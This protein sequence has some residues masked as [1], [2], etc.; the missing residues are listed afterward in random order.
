MQPSAPVQEFTIHPLENGLTV[1]VEEM[2]WAS[3]AAMS[4]FLPLGAATD[5]EG[6][7]G[8]SSLLGELMQ[9]GAGEFDSRG[10]SEAFESLGIHRS[11]S[12]GVAGSMFSAVCLPEHLSEAS[13][14]LG[15]QLLSP[16]LPESDYPAV[17]ALALQELASLEDE[18]ASKVMVEL[19]KQFFP[20][21]FNRSQLG[22]VESVQ[23]ISLQDVERYHQTRI[24]PQGAIIGVAGKVSAQ[25]VIRF[26]EEAFGGW[27]GAADI[28]LPGALPTETQKFH[29]KKETAQLQLAL[30]YPSVDYSSPDYYSARVATSVLSGG[31]FGRLFVE[32]REKRGLV[33]RVSA[34]HQASKG[35]GA[36][37]VYAGTTPE[38][39]Q[40]CMDVT[41]K[42]LRGLSEGIPTDEL[43]RAKAD[44]KSRLVM[45][46]ELSSNRSAALVHDWWNLGRVR[47]VNEIKDSI[48]KVSSEDISSF[49]QKHPPKPLTLVCMGPHAVELSS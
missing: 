44:L 28:P 34:S 9:K 48:Q 26:V 12:V 15:L 39:G 22:T 29:V 4:I 10:I 40:E 21:P 33:Y 6:Q 41:L 43:E 13:N 19:S 11:H 8:V 2:P 1:I 7:E 42:E 47:K 20:Q 3:S 24:V 14:L 31:M 5:P 16:R 17:K 27:K 25:E 30:A 37:M 45:G 38:N 23:N 49:C 46:S 18:P 32:V 36:T 35:R